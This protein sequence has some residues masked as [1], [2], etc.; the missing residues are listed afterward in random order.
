MEN[1]MNTKWFGTTVHDLLSKGA[2]N[3]LSMLQI[4]RRI[5]PGVNGWTAYE[6]A[7]MTKLTPQHTN[8]LLKQLFEAGY[9]DF[10][11]VERRGGRPAR[12]WHAK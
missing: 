10:V 8:R 3:T 4:M 9:V 5:H 7:R 2:Q 12:E 11:A 6:L 1:D